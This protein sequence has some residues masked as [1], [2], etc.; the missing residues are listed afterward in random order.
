MTTEPLAPAKLPPAPTLRD[1]GS[2]PRGK[3]DAT[4]TT[5]GMSG[6]LR[7]MLRNLDLT[8]VRPSQLARVATRLFDEGKISEDTASEFL[9]ARRP[10]ADK[11]SD[12]LPFNLID[13]MQE[14]LKRSGAIT[15]RYPSA[16]SGRWY[17]E[18][19]AAA[20][21]LT[22]VIAYLRKHPRIDVHA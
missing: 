20:R 2:G 17:A 11:L 12:D 7:S 19:G 8:K 18:A 6:D 16:E 4:R 15:G 1:L 3:K 9:L 22:E 21:G 13:A 10:R 5:E 14:G